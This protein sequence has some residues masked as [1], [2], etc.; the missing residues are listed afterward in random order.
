MKTKL[1]SIEIQ[2]KYQRVDRKKKKNK[3]NFIPYLFI[4]IRFGLDRKIY[5]GPWPFKFNLILHLQNNYHFR[6]FNTILN[7]FY[8]LKTKYVSMI[9]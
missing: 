1:W 6:F 2:L 8:S 7:I 4:K 9:H 3:I 5:F